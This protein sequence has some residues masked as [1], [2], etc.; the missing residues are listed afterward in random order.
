MFAKFKEKYPDVDMQLTE[1]PNTEF[2]SKVTA[3]ITGGTTPDLMF[4]MSEDAP[5][6]LASGAFEPLPEGLVN[7]DDFFDA[8]WSSS[9]YD[10]VAY[11]VPWYN[12]ANF[13][14]FRS[15]LMAA[16]DLEVPKTWDETV[17]VAKKLKESGVEYPVALAVAWDQ[18]TGYQ[19]GVLSAANGGGLMNEDN[20]EWTIDTPEN[21]AALEWWASLV[22]EGLASADGPAFLD[23]VAWSTNGT[24]AILWDSGPWFFSWF[25]DA[26]GEG[27]TDEH[28]TIAENPTSPTGG[29]ASTTGGGVWLVPSD[30]KNADGGW[31]FAQW[32]AEKEQQVEWYKIFSN[33]P[34]L[35]AA[36]DDPVFA[37]NPV[38]EA[39]KKSLETGYPRPPVATWPEVG[40]MLGKQM[41]RVVREG[42][43]PA[44][45]LAEAQKQAESIGTGR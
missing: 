12:Y 42:V 36:W 28:M 4:V 31:R 17:E 30:A 10:G 38:S 1:I 26:N 35:K 16:A 23:T 13:T 7:K 40:D 39:V 33:M 14:Y 21:L 5:A 45:A 18:Y 24:N 29:T 19:L 6:V 44:E 22:D 32:M 37:E 15:D 43:S 27:W 25:R 11:G 9:V 20:S 34:A 41:E 3:A 8:I 2:K